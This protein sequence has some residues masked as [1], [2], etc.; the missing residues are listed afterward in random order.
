MGVL[1]L[2]AMAQRSKVESTVQNEWHHAVWHL[3]E[4]VAVA[5]RTA[6]TTTA[7]AR[8]KERA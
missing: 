7:R 4:R 3:L 5:P 8:M 6:Y 2:C 1:F